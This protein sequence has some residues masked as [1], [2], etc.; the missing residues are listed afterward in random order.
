[1]KGA[2][3]VAEDTSD[4][5]IDCRQT[6]PIQFRERFDNGERVF[7]ERRSLMFKHLQV[8][9]F[10]DARR[11]VLV[12]LAYSARVVEVSPKNSVSAVAVGGTREA[13]R[14]SAATD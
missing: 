8:V 13:R 4:A 1:V 2:P 10:C 7:S 3:G 9:R 14:C 12:Y 6:G 11:K 5:S